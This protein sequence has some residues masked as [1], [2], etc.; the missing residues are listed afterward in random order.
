M[1]VS[2]CSLMLTHIG[3]RALFVLEE[4]IVQSQS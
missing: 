3:N 4:R 2:S 1:L